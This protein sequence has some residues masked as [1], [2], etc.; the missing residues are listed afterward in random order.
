MPVS[1]SVAPVPEHIVVVPAMV[2]VG[3]VTTGIVI[4]E[5]KAAVQSG[6]ELLA[7]LTKA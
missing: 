4:F 6:G 2:A 5:L 3:G 1:V 7:M